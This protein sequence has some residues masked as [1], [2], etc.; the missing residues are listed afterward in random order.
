M[1]AGSTERSASTRASRGR[2]FP[3]LGINLNV[4][5]P[6]EPMT[7]YH[8][9]EAQKDFLILAGDCTLIVQGE[10]RPL[11]R[12]DLFHCPGV[13]H[14]IVGAGEGR[15][16]VLAVGARTGD[17]EKGLVYPAHPVA[18]KHGAAGR[19]ETTDPKAACEGHSFRR[20]AY[21]EGWLPDA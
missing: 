15:S 4:L 7:M 21:E 9:E 13:D 6:G 18:Q 10:E 19:T 5:Q 1:Q 16:L 3:Q 11:R 17:E 12:W 2:R 8:R 20:C 14:A